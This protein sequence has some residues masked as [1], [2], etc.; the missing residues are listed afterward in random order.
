MADLPGAEREDIEV[1]LADR[2]L[3]IGVGRAAAGD[4]THRID[5]K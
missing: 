2:T 1:S 5:V 3:T 4:D